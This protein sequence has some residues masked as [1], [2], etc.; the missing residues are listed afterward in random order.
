MFVTTCRDR[1]TRISRWW[2]GAYVQKFH[3]RRSS[4]QMTVVKESIELSPRVYW[5]ILSKWSYDLEF[6]IRAGIDYCTV[7]AHGRV[8]P[9][10]I[11]LPSTRTPTPLL[12]S[13]EHNRRRMHSNLK[14][15]CP[16]E[17]IIHFLSRISL[18]VVGG[19]LSVVTQ[20]GRSPYVCVCSTAARTGPS[21][22]ASRLV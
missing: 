4:I 20:H 17:F 8:V 19:C 13:H 3:S 5:K 18:M 12:L 10:E 15:P 21:V 22:I 6:R 7:H 14:Q 9:I 2:S 11:V 16:W 1:G